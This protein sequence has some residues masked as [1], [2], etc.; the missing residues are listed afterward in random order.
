MAEHH[1]Q[2][3][4]QLGR[5]GEESS[6][7]SGGSDDSWLEL[8]KIIAQENDQGQ[9]VSSTSSTPSFTRSS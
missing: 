2:F 7:G 1:L 4:G 9:D 6:G 3:H 8:K 5:N